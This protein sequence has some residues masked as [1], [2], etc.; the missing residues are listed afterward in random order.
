MTSY[1]QLLLFT[2]HEF[3]VPIECNRLNVKCNVIWGERI[4]CVREKKQQLCM[5]NVP[6]GDNKMLPQSQWLLNEQRQKRISGCIIIIIKVERVQYLAVVRL[7]WALCDQT[8]NCNRHHS[9]DWADY[10]ASLPY[11]RNLDRRLAVHQASV[12]PIPFYSS[13]RHCSCAHAT[14]VCQWR[15]Y[16]FWVPHFSLDYS[17]CVCQQLSSYPHRG[18]LYRIHNRNR[19]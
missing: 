11:P 9:T 15:P 13:A 17:H 5:S 10:S 12:S 14:R 1:H 4:M 16:G 7:F 3:S 2:V 6:N 18:I 19:I 8:D